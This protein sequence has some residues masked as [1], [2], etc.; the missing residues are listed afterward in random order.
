MKKILFFLIIFL[1]PADH[2][3]S[4]TNKA[5]HSFAGCS[6]EV[7]QK[8]LENIDKLKIKKIEIDTHNYR[9][10]T[11]NSVRILT[12][13]SRYTEDKYKNRFNA[14]V[15]VD[16]GDDGKCIFREEKVTFRINSQSF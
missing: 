2:L 11:V 9:R 3:L 7:S 1:V 13:R 4:T 12:S 6:I 16:Y 14:T 15:T 10:W 5:T 8:Y